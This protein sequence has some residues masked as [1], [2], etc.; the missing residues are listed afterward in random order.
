[1]A[2]RKVASRASKNKVMPMG[3]LKSSLSF[4]REFTQEEY[5]RLSLGLIPLGMDE[6]WFIFLENNCLYFH[7]SWTG[8]CIYQLRLEKKEND[9][10]VAETWVQRDP[11]KYKERDL[12]YDGFFHLLEKS[13]VRRS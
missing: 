12:A 7:R 9:Y 1:M 8:T 5:D 11:D 4:H 10:V 2:E 6:K 3:K 13:K